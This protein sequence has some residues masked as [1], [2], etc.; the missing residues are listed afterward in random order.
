MLLSYMSQP[1]S[2]YYLSLIVHPKLE[3]Y[4]LKCFAPLHSTPLPLFL[5]GNPPY[6]KR[7]HFFMSRRNCRKTRF[8]GK[9]RISSYVLHFLTSF[10][11]STLETK[12][13]TKQPRL[14]VCLWF[15]FKY[16]GIKH[17]RSFCLSTPNLFLIEKTNSKDL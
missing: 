4:Y 8:C 10:S 1:P 15:S 14:C 11:S 3:S 6:C 16:F 5:R 12:Y 2:L 7:E 13:L 17:K 9:S